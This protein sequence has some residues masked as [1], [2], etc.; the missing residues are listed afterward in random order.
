MADRRS[1]W[2][3]C[4]K[5]VHGFAVPF[6]DAS[7][8]EVISPLIERV[9][10]NSWSQV[11]DQRSGN[12][13]LADSSLGW[14]L[15]SVESTEALRSKE[16]RPNLASGGNLPLTFNLPS[17]VTLTGSESINRQVSGHTSESSG[18]ENIASCFSQSDHG[19]VCSHNSELKMNW[20]LFWLV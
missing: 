20:F 14:F 12:S 7:A 5:T 15:L 3:T 13:A 1:V 17:E 16:F 8:T 10:Q 2:V 9:N 19:S 11:T 18:L 6:G 4:L